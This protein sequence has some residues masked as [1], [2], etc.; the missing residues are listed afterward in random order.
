MVWSDCIVNWSRVG[1]FREENGVFFDIIVI[2]T[3]I[4]C[5]WIVKG[6]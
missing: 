3:E 4:L 5:V 6:G 2:G 1:G